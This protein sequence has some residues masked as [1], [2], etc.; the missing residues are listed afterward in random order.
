MKKEKSGTVYVLSI[1]LNKQKY[2]VMDLKGSLSRS[3]SDSMLFLYES[4]AESYAG[5]VEHLVEEKTEEIATI[6]VIKLPLSRVI[7]GTWQ[8]DV[9]E[10]ATKLAL[11][12]LS[13]ESIEQLA[14]HLH[15]ALES[16]L[17]SNS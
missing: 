15:K 8:D 6:R 10:K 16:T 9:A 17:K 1:D 3:I 2:Y 14:N 5:P 7:P 12:D 4:I 11:D 13:C